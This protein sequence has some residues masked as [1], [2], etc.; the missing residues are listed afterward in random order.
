MHTRT[1]SAL[2]GHIRIMPTVGAAFVPMGPVEIPLTSLR[3][4]R[5]I[6]HI[7]SNFGAVL[8]GPA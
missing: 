3:N 5:K 1:T 8:Y 4:G 6:P 2:V 7:V